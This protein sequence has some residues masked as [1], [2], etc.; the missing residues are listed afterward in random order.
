MA[1]YQELNEADLIDYGNL[2]KQ[3][4]IKIPDYSGTTFQTQVSDPNLIKWQ[5]EVD[6]FLKRQYLFLR[7]FI[8]DPLSKQWLQTSE[9]RAT[10][11]GISHVLQFLS[12]ELYKTITLSNLSDSDVLRMAADA[13]YTMTEIFYLNHRK[14]E[15]DKQDCTQILV[16]ADHAILANLRR[17]YLEG[18]R[19]YH[20]AVQRF[21]ENIVHQRPAKKMGGMGELWQ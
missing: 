5:L 9:P 12:N 8:K 2:L 19:R 6:A 4:D 7:G 21:T 13:R 18:E 11:E 3:N 20:K 15:M 1:R 16:E 10:E 14:W 17:A